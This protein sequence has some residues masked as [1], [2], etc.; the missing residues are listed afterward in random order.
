MKKS[1]IIAIIGV[2]VSI[3]VI[4]ALLSINT[5]PYLKV[6]QVV[7]HSTRYDNKEI[8]IIGIVEGY[9]SSDFNLTEGEHSIF[10]DINNISP[11]STLKNGIEVVVIGI[12]SSN[13]ILVAEQILTQCS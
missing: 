10:I 3:G 2:V 13:L 11:P 4:I 5:R 8:Q 9:V 6:S 7:S 1:R 12:F